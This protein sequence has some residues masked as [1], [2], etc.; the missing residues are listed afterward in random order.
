VGLQ[1]QEDKNGVRF[2]AKVLEKAKL[3]GRL[4]LPGT[5]AL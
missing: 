3:L 2:N 1:V 4:I 5:D